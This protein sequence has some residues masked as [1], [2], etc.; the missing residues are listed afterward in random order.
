MAPKSGQGQDRAAQLDH[1]VHD[2]VKNYLEI[3]MGRR[4]HD[5]RR[6]RRF[7]DL[8][9]DLR[10]VLHGENQMILRSI[11]T[12]WIVLCLALGSWIAWMT[13]DNE[14]PYDWEGSPASFMTPDPAPQGGFVTANWKLTKVN[15]LCPATLQ[16][17]FRNH[18]TGEL[19]A[20][21]DTT[22]PRAP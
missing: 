19:V 12:L 7:H 2:C 9:E 15:R 8:V 1:R 3:S 16:R 21:L 20:T 5:P 14:S 11:V 18:L 17:S 22:K 6:L 4:R 13:L 10:G